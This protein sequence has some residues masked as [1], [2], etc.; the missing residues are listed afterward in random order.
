[1]LELETQQQILL[2]PKLSSAIRDV[3]GDSWKIEPLPQDGSCSP[4]A[5][6]ATQEGSA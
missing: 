4:G 2:D 5:D 3:T 6:K 1:M